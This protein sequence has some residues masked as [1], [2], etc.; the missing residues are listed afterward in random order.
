MSSALANLTRL[1][2]LLAK[3]LFYGT[4]LATSVIAVGCVLLS[5]GTRSGMPPTIDVLAVRCLTGGIALLIL[6][7]VAR[8]AIM[9]WFFLQDRDYRLAVAAVLVLGTIAAGVAIGIH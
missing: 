9:L 3:F 7:P 6:L 8:V 2:S 5:V 4:W 1:E